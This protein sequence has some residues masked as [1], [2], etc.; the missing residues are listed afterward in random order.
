MLN[1]KTQQMFIVGE[2]IHLYRSITNVYPR[3]VKSFTL[4]RKKSITYKN[5]TLR[6]VDYLEV[7]IEKF[8]SVLK[9]YRRRKSFIVKTDRQESLFTDKY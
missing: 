6:E 8:R 7:S 3:Y 9:M 5:P 4:R 1:E 2:V